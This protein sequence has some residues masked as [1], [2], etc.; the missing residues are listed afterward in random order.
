MVFEKPTAIRWTFLFFLPPSLSILFV[1]YIR[2]IAFKCKYCHR[3]WQFGF[4]AH[5]NMI[6]MSSP[7]D[8]YIIYLCFF[9]L[10]FVFISPFIAMKMKYTIN[11]Y[12]RRRPH[13]KK[14][15]RFRSFQFRKPANCTK[16]K[17]I[18]SLA[19]EHAI[20]HHLLM[21]KCDTER[22]GRC[23]RGITWR[24]KKELNT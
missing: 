20:T 6:K 17:W 2:A 15:F 4:A 24:K 11:H 5:P 19:S 9:F 12:R 7:R 3:W 1:V 18:L 8:I 14:S 10:S 16:L 21:H 23:R 22:I 13:Q